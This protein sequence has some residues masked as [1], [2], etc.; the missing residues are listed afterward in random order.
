VSLAAALAEHLRGAQPGGAALTVI[1]THIS[2]LLLG[3]DRAWKLKKPLT[4]DF[5]DFGSV[6]ARR[7]G[8]EEELRIN[9]RT[10]PQ[11][12]RA[13]RPVLGTSDAPHLGQAD[14]ADD[15][16]RAIDWVVEMHRFDER[17]GL[18]RL[19]ARG[20]LTPARID[21]MAQ[22]MAALHG[23]AP[24]C[25]P[26]EAACPLPPVDVDN[27]RHWVDDNFASLRALPGA[28]PW[29]DEIAWLQRWSTARHARLAPLIAARHRGGRVVECH[30]DLHLGNWVLIDGAPVAFDAIE[31]E[32][33]LRWIDVVADLA[34]PFMDLLA[35]G[36]RGLAWRLVNAWFESTGDHEGA[37]LLSWFAVYR[38]LVRVKIALIEATQAGDEAARAERLARARAGLDLARTLADEAGQRPVLFALGG[39]SGSGKSTVG[40]C[41]VEQFGALRLRSD[42]E[43]K[44]LFGMRAQQRPGQDGAVDAAQLYSRE[45]TE[46]TYERL[47]AL[48]RRLLAA[49]LS[50]VFDAASLRVDERDQR[51]RLADA[52]GARHLLLQCSAPPE[53]LAQRLQA[54]QARGDDASDADVAVMRRQCDY[55][56][57]LTGT[58]QREAVVIDTDRPPA[59]L[60]TQVARQLRE[61]LA[62]P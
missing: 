61:V 45:A 11:V 7:H 50:V 13:V 62:T 21:G 31:F 29:Q 41:C 55:A 36:Q 27:A 5:L 32:P 37:A 6:A 44:R 26:G 57:P 17:Q 28:A 35:R 40:Q 25:P 46:R 14:D 19:A 8:C 20:E 15:A 2:V 12:Y 3:H 30:G 48:T 58:E 4:L 23:P 24:L 18:D 52:T 51:R 16:A 22:V 59:T 9:R 54:R 38:A 60:C 10:A 49:G 43:R 56:E 53:V 39:L 33:R 47:G 34:F 1:E 42:V